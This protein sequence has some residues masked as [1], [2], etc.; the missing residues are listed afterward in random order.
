MPH[1]L[2]AQPSTITQRDRPPT[3]G[4]SVVGVEGSKTVPLASDCL[5]D[6][7]AGGIRLEFAA[8]PLNERP[9]VVAIPDVLRPPHPPSSTS[10]SPRPAVT[11][12]QLR[13]QHPLA[14]QELDLEPTAL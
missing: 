8:Q 4:C 3:E 1:I 12:R 9:Q 5:N 7:G 2:G 13:V 6:G 10:L 14:W 11:A